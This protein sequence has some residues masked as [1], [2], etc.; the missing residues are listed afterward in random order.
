MN[1]EDIK[2]LIEE[3][4]SILDDDNSDVYDFLYA[5]I[6]ELKELIK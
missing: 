1:K 5:K 2:L 6:R 4:Q 3:M